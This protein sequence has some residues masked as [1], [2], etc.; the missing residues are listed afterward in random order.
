MRGIGQS[1]ADDPAPFVMSRWRRHENPQSQ[2]NGH[3]IIL[4]LQLV[5]L[6]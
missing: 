6:G 2:D 4:V 5:P 3:Y 1:R